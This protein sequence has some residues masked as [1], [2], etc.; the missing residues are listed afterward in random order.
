MGRVLLGSLIVA[1]FAAVA[2][3]GIW[4]LYQA[5]GG[6]VPFTVSLADARG[7][8]A[9]A[10]VVYRDRMVGRVVAMR[11]L[12]GRTL[13]D[14]RLSSEHA[15]IL[16]QGS[17]FWVQENLGGAFLCFDTPT[18][19][20]EPLA[21]GSI[22]EGLAAR[23]DPDEPAE[24][25]PRKLQARP[26]WLCEVRVS[27]TVREGASMVRDERRKAAAA[28]VGRREGG[29]LVLAPSWVLESFEGELAGHNAF[30]EFAGGETCVARPSAVADGLALLLVEETSWRGDTATLWHETLP[31]LQTLALVNFQ[32]D[33]WL[34]E[35]R[36]G[37]L[38]GGLTL[39]HGC[40]AM[41][42]GIK[43]CGFA[44]PAANTQTA[45]RW[46]GLAAAARLLHN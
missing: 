30:V 46:I 6:G 7:L 44:L 38:A 42:D 11:V 2:V 22:L 32:S 21:P 25:R 5:E 37:T 16:R 19:A 8:E 35:Y 15:G 40:V 20:G 36:D 17:R 31:S 45:P 10:R 23:P 12:Q 1:V 14:C 4:L 43:L 28:V 33:M 13:A 34:A 26:A 41:V 3:G 24:V 39:V 27:A 29:V 18:G 9:G